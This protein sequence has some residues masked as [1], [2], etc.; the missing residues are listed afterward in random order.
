[1]K[2]KND[3]D[4]VVGVAEAWIRVIFVDVINVI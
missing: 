2:G 1:M 4:F 3:K